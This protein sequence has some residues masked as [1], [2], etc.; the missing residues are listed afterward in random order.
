MSGDIE[1]R[2]SSALRLAEGVV[3]VAVAVIGIVVGFWVLHAIAG[4]LWFL[5]KVVVILGVIGAVLF[6][7]KARRRSS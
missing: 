6:V 1:E 2:S 7:L 4:V 5:I 3:L